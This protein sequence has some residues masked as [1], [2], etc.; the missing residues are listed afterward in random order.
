M[1]LCALCHKYIDTELFTEGKREGELQP[2]CCLIQE[3]ELPP[4]W[5]LPLLFPNLSC[6]C[7]NPGQYLPCPP[8]SPL[9]SIQGISSCA[10]VYC[11][12]SPAPATSA[13]GWGGRM[14]V[15]LARCSAQDPEHHCTLRIATTELSRCKPNSLWMNAA[16]SLVLLKLHL[17]GHKKP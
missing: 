1:A 5:I 6:S 2:Q 17:M 14:M 10:L 15:M 16:W 4:H 7:R 13:P 3:Q 8:C 12:P 11:T 9:A